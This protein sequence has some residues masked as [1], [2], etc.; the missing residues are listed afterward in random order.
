MST[1]EKYPLLFEV[2]TLRTLLDHTR[3]ASERRATFSQLVDG[4]YRLDGRDWVQGRDSDETLT[5]AYVDRR[6]IPP[7][8]TLVGDHGVYLMSNGLPPLQDPSP[9][10]S[11]S[12]VAYALGI[13]PEQDSMWL[14]AKRAAFGGDDG[15]EPIDLESIEAAIEGA[16]PESY[17][18]MR[19][20]P[21]GIEILPETLSARTARALAANHYTLGPASGSTFTL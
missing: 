7:G 21:K 16:A 15:T 13:N 12:L 17:L 9:E 4:R 11:R 10:I 14:D 1:I 19:I 5:E 8:L 3:G 2:K 18:H 6:K 20:W